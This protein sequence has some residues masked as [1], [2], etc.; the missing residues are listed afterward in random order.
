MSREV[1]GTRYRNPLNAEWERAIAQNLRYMDFHQTKAFYTF[2][3]DK[4]E[5]LHKDIFAFLAC[6]DRFFLLTYILGRKDAMHPWLFNRCREVEANP[7]G[8]IDL[9][10]RFHYKSSIITFAGA[11]QEILCDPEIT[12]AIFSVTQPIA[13]KFLSQIKNEFEANQKLALYFGDVLWQKPKVEAPTW[14]I[15][16]GITVRRVGNKKEATLEAHGLIDAQPTGR[17]FDLHIYDDVVTQDYMSKDMIEKTTQRWELA[18]NLGSH[19]G[20]RKWVAGTRYNF[21]DTYGVMMDRKSFIPR[22]YPATANGKL[23]GVPVFLSKKR[24][25]EIK[26]DQQSTVSAQMLLNPAYGTDATFN[27]IWLKT[28]EVIPA[29]MNVYIMVDPSKGRGERSDRTAIAVIGTDPAGN[30]YFLDGVRHRMKLYDRYTY[31]RNLYH[32]WLSHPGVQIV[33]V[34]YEIYGQQVDIEVIQEYQQK[35]SDYFVIKELNTPASGPHAKDDRIG[36]LE[37]DIRLGTFYFPAVVYHPDFRAVTN[38]QAMWRPWL[39]EDDARAD[40]TDE[41]AAF[42]VGQIIYRP[43]RGL[44]KLQRAVS[45]DRVVTA[46][47]RVDE[48]NRVYDVT[49]AA[50]EEIQF[51]PFGGY[52]DLV[53]AMSR[54]Y[55]MDPHNP[56]K[57]EASML[58]GVDD[59]P[60]PDWEETAGTEVLYED[61]YSIPNSSFH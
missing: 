22:I 31:M 19:V 15:A 60:A 5:G 58:Q 36:R 42:K 53:D 27:P 48:S 17:H 52:K 50:I 1:R 11:I 33:E 61:E 29:V 39:D 47:R 3:A 44:T 20:A 34:G 49:R 12:I 6:N 45:A 30:K 9:W 14:S 8:H 7:D 51:H 25:A 46:V 57:F 54:I 32:K 4:A 59:G 23:D 35:D 16:G 55:D 26:R 56:E 38:G 10:A 40:K 37:P 18:D 43:L 24:W 21:A 41:E 13:R 2:L 28:Y